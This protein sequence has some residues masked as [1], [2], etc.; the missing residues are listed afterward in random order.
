MQFEHL[1]PD[2]VERAR[3]CKTPEELY[4]LAKEEGMELSDAELESVSGGSWEGRVESCSHVTCTSYDCFSFDC[5][6][7][8]C[9]NFDCSIFGQE[10]V[11]CSN[12]SCTIN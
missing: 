6:E 11:G 3:A 4:A 2:Y 8:N 1:S 10:G 5:G 9:G 7:V 12:L